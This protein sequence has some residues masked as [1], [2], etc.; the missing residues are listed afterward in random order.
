LLQVIEVEQFIFSYN[1]ERKKLNSINPNSC[2]GG[3]G[4]AGLQSTQN[5]PIKNI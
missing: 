4:L 3:G 2:G 1:N 5:N